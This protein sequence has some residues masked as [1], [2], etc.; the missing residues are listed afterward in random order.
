[1]LD[2][3][4][5]CVYNRITERG[6]TPKERKEARKMFEVWKIN[7]RGVYELVKR[8]KNAEKAALTGKIM[9]ANGKWAQM[10]K[11]G[12]NKIIGR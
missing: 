5:H 8:T 6:N 10:C 1:M 12:E 11:A 9:R 3:Y 2:F 7:D 4:T